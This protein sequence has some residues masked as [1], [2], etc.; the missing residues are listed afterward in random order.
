MPPTNTTDSGT[1]FP[2]EMTSY[3]TSFKDYD[4]FPFYDS[5]NTTV[6]QLSNGS[7]STTGAGVVPEEASLLTIIFVSILVGILSLITSGGN[8]LVM[9]SFKMDKQL[10]TITNCYL[11]SLSVADFFIGVVSMP[12]FTVYLLLN[13]WP[14]G[15]IVCDTWLSMD[16][17]MSNASVANLLII[18][19]DRYFTV[20]RPLTYRARRTPKKAGFLI[21]LAWGIS[22][23]LWT[24][25]IWTWPYIEGERK[26]PENQCYIQFLETNQYITVVTAF[27]AFYL[28]V[29]IMCVLYYKIYQATET[30]RRDLAYLQPGIVRRSFAAARKKVT[31][32]APAARSPDG[33]N[34]PP[35]VPNTQGMSL[36][37]QKEL[38]ATFHDALLAESGHKSG[39]DGHWRRCIGRC[40]KMDR[41]GEDEQSSSASNPVGTS[42]STTPNINRRPRALPGCQEQ[43]GAAASAAGIDHHR[44]GHL[45]QKN[46]QKR[47]PGGGLSFDKRNISVDSDVLHSTMVSI[48]PST[49]VCDYSISRQM[50]ELQLQEQCAAGGQSLA[51]ICQM[52]MPPPSE[53]HVRDFLLQDRAPEVVVGSSGGD[54]NGCNFENTWS[55]SRQDAELAFNKAC[56]SMTSHPMTSLP[57]VSEIVE[58]L[59]CSRSLTPCETS[60]FP[61][62]TIPDSDSSSVAAGSSET[63]SR[64]A[65]LAGE[66]V[67]MLRVALQTRLAGS[68]GQTPVPQTKSAQR[69][70]KKRQE[71]RQE[72]KA[73]KTLSAILL[74]F[75]V[76][77]TPYN[78]FILINAFRYPET[79]NVHLYNFGES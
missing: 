59:V 41:E 52:S 72:R 6:A 10:Q 32:R 15:Q 24:P 20:T 35:V 78:V 2:L 12:L 74:A 25:W 79:M 8:L 26:V 63:G 17:T 64:R 71:K 33:M 36:E 61:A 5:D 44:P 1:F 29:F 19:F 67:D 27:A 11:L 50:S 16:Y 42:L 30:R 31:E 70:Q 46:G 13:R 58:D 22:V 54:D 68:R 55:R 14:L 51:V 73:A 18:S 48:T 45:L 39:Q 66:P 57:L 23:L 3:T 7:N 56:K 9:M 38:E 28:P 43:S 76:T 62:H 47:A 49:E 60:D 4:L 21:A 40:W 34:S 65:R 77:W 69:G 37:L 75:V 53:Q